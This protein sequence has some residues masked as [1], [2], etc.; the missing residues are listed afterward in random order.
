MRFI[1]HRSSPIWWHSRVGPSAQRSAWK[2]G[3]RMR[4]LA[5]T[6]L[7]VLLTAGFALAGPADV[8]SASAKCSATV[9]DFVVTVR[10]HDAGW[11]HFANAWQILAPD[12][13]VLATRVLRHP[14]VDEQPFTRELR[15]VEI[16]AVLSEV[17]IRARDSLHGLGGKEV[18][19]AVRNLR[20]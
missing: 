12:G 20:E 5:A 1:L 18:V 10:H 7:V 4:L 6:S 19:V 8:V 11:D 14:H 9:C 16:P 2:M 15:G 17:R 3:P 13:S